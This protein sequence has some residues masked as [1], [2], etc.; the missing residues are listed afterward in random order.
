[1][2]EYYKSH[3]YILSD[4]I[5]IHCHVV[6]FDGGGIGIESCP[7]PVAHCAILSSEHTQIDNRPAC[8]IGVHPSS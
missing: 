8:I 2:I 4:H 1:M 6:G 5:S 3:V 7:L